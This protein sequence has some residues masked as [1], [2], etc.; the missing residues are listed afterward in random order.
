[1]KNNQNKIH[2]IISGIGNG[3]GGV[4]NY[5]EYLQIKYADEK[6]RV[7][8]PVTLSLRNRFVSRL[9]SI[10]DSYIFLRLRLFFLPKDARITLISQQYLGYLNVKYVLKNFKNINLYLMDNSWFCLS[11]Y[12]HISNT[13]KACFSCLG[14]EYH[15]SAKNSC[16]PLPIYRSR[17]NYLKLNK[18]I[19]LYS[20]EINFIFLSNQNQQLALRHFGQHI[21][22]KIMPHITEEL[23]P[24]RFEP[25]RKDST[26]VFDFV[27]HAADIE[28]KGLEYSLQLALHLKEYSFYI[29]TNKVVDLPNV[30]TGYVNWENG[31]KN[32]VANSRFILTPSFWSY[33]PE[34]STLKSFLHNGCVGLI[35]DEFNY[36]NDIPDEAYVKL[37]GDPSK[38]SVMLRKVLSD[39][40]LMNTLKMRSKSFIV[41]YFNDAK[42]ELDQYF[43]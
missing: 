10:I 7:V 2:Y 31:L 35:Q 15:W 36:S 27:L 21:N 17:N 42:L 43:S 24:N 18:L 1:M 29:P 16:K 9:I 6:C 41:Q 4:G 33:T 23:N 40:E 39:N 5:I 12:N 11:S 14:G 19:S 32:I 13:N 20:N 25:L 28:V 3:H 30:E 8:A 22:S 26:S 34:T 38:D 37:S